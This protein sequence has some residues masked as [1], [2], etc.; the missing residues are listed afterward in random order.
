VYSTVLDGTWKPFFLCCDIADGCMAIAPFGPKVPKDVQDLVMQTKDSIESG[1]MTL[2]AGPLVDQDGKARVARGEV[3]SV[4]AMGSLD[5]FVKGVQ[6][7]PKQEFSFRGAVMDG[8]RIL[9]AEIHG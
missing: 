1:K 7:S 5:W 9:L 3:L 6:G 8:R 4:E 2:F